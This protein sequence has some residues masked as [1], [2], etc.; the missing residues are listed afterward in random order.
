MALQRAGTR[1]SH[2][3]SWQVALQ[4]GALGSGRNGSIWWRGCAKW[5]TKLVDGLCPPVLHLPC[6]P[7]PPQLP[8]HLPE[9]EEL[10]GGRKPYPFVLPE[11]MV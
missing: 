9:P 1:V 2:I 10:L 11:Q 6:H 5:A 4:K 8:I 7:P 3:T